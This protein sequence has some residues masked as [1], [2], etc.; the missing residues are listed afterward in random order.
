MQYSPD[1]PSHGSRLTIT[2]AEE[3]AV[4]LQG[5]SVLGGRVRRAAHLPPYSLKTPAGS[6]DLNAV[7]CVC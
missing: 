3:T 6:V 2:V 4:P 7:E 5:H 1:F